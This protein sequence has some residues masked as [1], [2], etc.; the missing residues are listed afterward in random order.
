MHNIPERFGLAPAK[1]TAI[2]RDFGTFGDRDLTLCL[3]ASGNHRANQ[4]GQPLPGTC[5]IGFVAQDGSKLIKR[6]QLVTAPE[7]VGGQHTQFAGIGTQ[8]DC[9]FKM[10]KCG[11]TTTGLDICSC[12]SQMGRGIKVIKQKCASK[13]VQGKFAQAKIKKN[14]SQNPKPGRLVGQAVNQIPQTGANV[15]RQINFARN[16]RI[17]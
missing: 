2:D 10:F 7:K 16:D 4:I 15:W 14:M 13:S 8:P 1:G 3:K 9:Y 6:T 5:V 12:Q 11:V 17:K